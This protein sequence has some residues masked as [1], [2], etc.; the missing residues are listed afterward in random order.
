MILVLNTTTKQFSIALLSDTGSIISEQ[1]IMPLKSGSAFFMPSLDFLIRHSCEDIKEISCVV[2]AIGPGS[3]TG[4]KVALS[5]AKGICFSMNIP[6]VG[7]SSLEALAMQ[8]SYSNI[9]VTAIIDS[10]KNEYFFAQFEF[11]DAMPVRKSPD[12]CIR[13]EEFPKRFH[14]TLFIGNDYD[15]QASLIKEYM[16]KDAMLAPAHLWH[17]NPANVGIL[18]IERLKKGDVDDILSIEPIYFRA[19]E[20]R[21]NP[22]GLIN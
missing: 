1:V 9:P 8:V 15:S 3:F 14:K 16:G 4:L 12:D 11:K 6:I 13:I 5:V 18:G 2:V 17:I 19:P 20:I 21:K 7:V 22:Y 10:R